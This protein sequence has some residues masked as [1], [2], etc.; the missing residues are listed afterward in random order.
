MLSKKTGNASS[1]SD[2]ISNLE[3]WGTLEAFLSG[4]DSSFM[5]KRFDKVKKPLRNRVLMLLLLLV[6]LKIIQHGSFN[7]FVSSYRALASVHVNAYYVLYTL[8][9]GIQTHFINLNKAC[10]APPLQYTSEYLWALTI[11]PIFKTFSL[12]FTHA[13]YSNLQEMD[14]KAKSTEGNKMHGDSVM[15]Y[16]TL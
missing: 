14:Y 7:M 12:L 10:P 2:G 1:G 16:Q 11:C 5:E 3:A 4:Q 8:Q 9:T 15:L 6:T 13:R